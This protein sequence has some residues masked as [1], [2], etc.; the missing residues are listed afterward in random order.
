[1]IVHISCTRAI[2]RWFQSNVRDIVQLCS[3]RWTCKVARIQIKR[4]ANRN[5]KCARGFDSFSVAGNVW[6]DRRR[7][8]DVTYA[9]FF[10]HHVEMHTYVRASICAGSRSCIRSI[11]SNL[12]K[13][14]M[15]RAFARTQDLFVAA[16]RLQ[17]L[18]VLPF[19][20][21]G[22]VL[23]VTRKVDFTVV[24]WKIYD[25]KAESSSIFSQ[26]GEFQ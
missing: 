14:A 18:G 7:K 16:T 24:S 19:C 13:F 20:D 15:A 21:L 10:A 5:V 22:R 23:D 26:T 11:A 12:R 25:D 4:D 1:M 6:P 2:V 8:P 17:F 9:M 3:H